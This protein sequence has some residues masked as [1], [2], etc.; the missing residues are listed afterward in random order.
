MRQAVRIAVLG[1]FDAQKHSHWATEAALFHA[2]SWLGFDVEPRWFPTPS[3]ESPDAQDHL[4]HFDGVWG[5]PGGPFRSAAGVLLGIQFARRRDLPYLGTC[6][7]F[8]Y[9]LIEF[10]RNVLGLADADTAENDSDSQNVVI[11]PVACGLPEGTPGGPKM[12][13]GDAVRPVKGTLLYE[14]CRT[15]TLRGEFFCSFEPNPQY[16]PRWE[17]AGLR[18]AARGPRG[19][20]WAF[21][22]PHKRFFVA[23]LFQPQLSS[24]GEQPHPIV[25][26]YLRACA[27]F[28]AS[29]K[30][31]MARSV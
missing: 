21:D 16:V 1:D 29:K 23:T 11:R 10:S 17:A 2:A 30:A 13:G 28:R 19:E 25:L 18:V 12:H 20:M 5:A 26:G 7:G 27:E 9:A 14:L 31:A 8:Q 4:A 3:L 15:E 6:A 24:Q 22:L